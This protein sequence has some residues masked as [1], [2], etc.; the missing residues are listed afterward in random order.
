MSFPKAFPMKSSKGDIPVPVVGFGTWA[1]ENTNWCYEATLT[2]LKTGN[3]HLD[4][5]WRYHVDD[6]VGAAIRDSEVPREEIF[7]TSKF[8]PNFGAPENV[9]KCLDLCLEAMGL[10]YIDLFLAHW[11][12]AFQVHSEEI[13]SAKAFAGNGD[14]D[15]AI[16]KGADG[17]PAIDWAHTAESIA[18][19]NGQQG[20]FKPTWQ[21]LQKLVKTGKVR[22][23][24]VSNFNIT[25]LREVMSVGGD[26]PL[27]CNQVEAHP[28]F[29][30]TELLKFMREQG[31]LAT[32]YCPLGGKGKNGSLLVEELLVKDLAA[33]H[34]MGV[35]Q[36]LQ[37]WAV[38]RGTIPLGKS[39]NA[40][41]IKANLDVRRLSQEDFEALN[42]MDQGKDGRIV[43][44][45][46]KWGVELY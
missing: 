17:K 2:A 19:A 13:G 33:K 37:S 6:Q 32:V 43:D 9:E 26:V 29:P 16:V 46:L 14:E 24:G 30:N 38:Q 8:W 15:M 10:D 44:L 31:I 5:A 1:S 34:G 39:Q 41:R 35:G 22:A 45:S 28:W 25:Q 7:I 12:V 23:I 3:R 21:A 20:S 42:G 4:C 11:P 36:L 40:E 27:S 18:T